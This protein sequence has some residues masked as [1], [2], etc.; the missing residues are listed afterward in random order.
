[1]ADLTATS[2][3]SIS[4][5][6]GLSGEVADAVQTY[7]GMFAGIRG[8]DHATTQGYVDA[9]NDEKGMIFAG[10][11]LDDQV[12]G[13]TSATPP[14]TNSTGTDASILKATAVTG[15][16]SRADIGK[17]VYATDSNVLTLTAPTY[18]TP[19]GIVVD[20]ATST[21]CDVLMLGLAAQ[22]ALDLSGQGIQ[23]L[24]LGHYYA[25]N[26]TDA[27]VV[28]SYP[29]P[30]HCSL[31]SFYAVCTKAI[32][33]GGGTTD[34]N[35]EIGTTNVTGTLQVTTAAGSTKGTVITQALSG[36]NVGHAGD[37]LSV[38]ATN[39][40]SLSGGEFDLYVKLRP[41]MGV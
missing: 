22:A 27:D 29:I 10:P 3:R 40:S 14:P 28:T 8:P 1:M 13:D 4:G 18:A 41:R 6:D 20:W 5:A 24:H 11:Q 25:A 2:K 36:S 30:F 26:V 33:G 38:E 12:L 35:C 9:Y 7:G 15:V 37:L 39:T 32:A 19:V 21:T 16:A 17:A 23:V 31:E 34:L